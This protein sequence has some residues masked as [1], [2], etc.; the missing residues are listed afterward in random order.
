MP[1]EYIPDGEQLNR[2]LASNPYVARPG[3]AKDLSCIQ[4]PIRS[5]TSTA[6]IMRI[7][8]AMMSVPPDE[9]GV[10]RSRWLIVRNSYPDLEA[11]TIPTWLQWFPEK[12]YGKFY[13]TA[14]FMHDIRFDV[15]GGRVEAEVH[16]ESF[17]GEEDIPSLMSREYTGAW[18]N[19]AQFYTRRFCVVLLSRTGY[20]PVPDGPKF[21]QLDMNAPPMGHWVPI[22]RG[23]TPMPEEWTESE[24]RA[25]TK[26]DDWE[27]L[28]QPP[29][30]VE[31]VDAQG[32]VTDYRINPLAE[33]AKIMGEKAIRALLNGRTK[34]EI[35]A[36]LMN[37]VLIQQ[38]GR[39]V[40]P[41]FV[42]D[43]HIAKQALRPVEGYPLHVG[44]DFGRQPAAVVMQN[45]G[46]RWFVLG[47]KVGSNMGAITFAPI[48]KRWL[49][50]TFP[51]WGGSGQPPINFWGDPSGD[52]KRGETDDNTAFQIWQNEGMLV[53][54]ADTGNRRTVRLETL[55]HL[56]GRIVH[57][58]PAI[59]Y[60]PTA[61]P[62]TTTGMGGGY[63]FRRKK[64]SGAPVYE[65]EPNKNEFSHPIDAHIE[66]LMGAGESRAMIGQNQR[67]KP[68]NTLMTHRPTARAGFGGRFAEVF[69]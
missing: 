38:P 45:V 4:G 36:E 17:A 27:F 47:E 56:L 40:F 68:V 31:T 2:Y 64:V 58:Q 3:N 59:V 53:R 42:R 22:M 24:R 63:C 18:I 48:V 33:N 60:D 62:I 39:P 25:H 52:H 61:C 43:T 41:Q 28:V 37:R 44:L 66:V 8:E 1:R 6:S 23:D 11:S 15:P 46:G 34:D 65:D 54:A 21:L 9:D 16:F 50:Q 26:P 55:T 57:G 10:R 49:A 5:G 7:Y 67:A 13:W 20:Y 12:V 51:G 19:E 29:W 35:D 69:R 32:N 30:F 14:P